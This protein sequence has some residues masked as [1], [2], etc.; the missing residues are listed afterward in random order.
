M[1]ETM[2]LTDCMRSFEESWFEEFKQEATKGSIEAQIT[3]SQ[4]LLKGIG[5]GRPN[6]NLGLQYLRNASRRSAE[7]CL[8]LGKMYLKGKY[9][10]ANITQAYFYLRLATL[11]RCKCGK[12]AEEYHA[13]RVSNVHLCYPTEATELLKLLPN[14]PQLEQKFKEEF[15]VWKGN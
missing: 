9:V 14:D 15:A 7:A 3:Y 10:P 11:Y 6:V 1:D 4:M 12:F 2:N 13:K 8:R 5:A